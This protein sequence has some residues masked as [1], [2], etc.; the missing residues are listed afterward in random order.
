MLE[1]AEVVL[2]H[3]RVE[4]RAVAVLV[5]EVLAVLLLLLRLVL[6]T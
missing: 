2:V 5:V 1:A 6:L 4:L 3:L